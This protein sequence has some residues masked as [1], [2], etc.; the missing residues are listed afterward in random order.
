MGKGSRSKVNHHDPFWFLFFGLAGF[1]PRTKRKLYRQ[2]GFKK[3]TDQLR[4]KSYGTFSRPST[5]NRYTPPVVILWT[6]IRAVA[7]HRSKTKEPL[8]SHLP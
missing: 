1:I 2:I 5:C 4:S 3:W 6:A 8:A 7:I